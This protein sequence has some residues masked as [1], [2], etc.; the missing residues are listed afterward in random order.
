MYEI[1]DKL[2]QA[3]E[4]L[5]LIDRDKEDF[6]NFR[7][8]IVQGAKELNR[9]LPTY[10]DLRNVFNLIKFIDLANRVNDLENK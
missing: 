9:D 10:E 5:E 8:Y 1:M 7:E 4:L 3:R 6:E 2:E